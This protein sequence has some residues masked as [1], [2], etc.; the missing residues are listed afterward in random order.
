ML[1]DD[2]SVQDMLETLGLMGLAWR[3]NYAEGQA[4]PICDEVELSATTTT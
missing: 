3:D 1:R 2:D 4:P